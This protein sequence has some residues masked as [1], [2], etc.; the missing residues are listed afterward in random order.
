MDNVK[1]RDRRFLEFVEN[2]LWKSPHQ[3]SP[4]VLIDWRAQ[5][6]TTP[7]GMEAAFDRAKEL[8][9]ESKTPVLIPL[10]GFRDILIG[11]ESEKQSSGHLGRAH[12][13][14]RYPSP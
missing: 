6:R 13:A 1:D 5:L 3:C 14:S 9:S 11:F 8:F 10:V 2:A 4:V 7:N 12:G